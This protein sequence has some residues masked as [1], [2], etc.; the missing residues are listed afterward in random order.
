MKKTL[1]PPWTRCAVPKCKRLYQDVHEPLTRA[2]GGSITDP[3]NSVP[4]CRR[5]NSELTLEPDWGYRLALLIHEWERTPLAV[6]ASVRR[7]LLADET[8]VED[9]AYCH[10]CRIW[11]VVGH[12][13]DT[14]PDEETVRSGPPSDLDIHEEQS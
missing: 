6:L 5:H 13:C 9:I 3:D 14:Q 4:V 2:R 12:D 11:R 10:H 7:Q 8:P 1:F